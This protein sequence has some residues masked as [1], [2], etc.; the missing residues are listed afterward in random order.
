MR[1]RSDGLTRIMN[2]LRMGGNILPASNNS[3]DLGSS[4]KKW[5]NVYSN[6]LHL[7]NEGHAND[8]DG[9]WGSYTI[10]EGEEDLFII[11]KRSGK[12]FKFVLQEVT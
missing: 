9:T 11:N 12:K 7:D 10:Q 1:L 4:S 2:D 5:A 6:D 8:V 3:Q